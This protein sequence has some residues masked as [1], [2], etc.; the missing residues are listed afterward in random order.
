MKSFGIRMWIN[1]I[2]GGEQILSVEQNHINNLNV[3]PVP[4][5]DTG[6]NMYTTISGGLMCVD[7]EKY[8]TFE[9]YAKILTK[10]MLMN[11]RGNS[12]VI[13]SQ[14]FRGF[15]SN[16]DTIQEINVDS[17]KESFRL[18]K[19]T[20]YKSVNDPVEGTILTIIREIAENISKK[21]YNE[22]EELF[23]DV[24]LFGQKSLD[25]TPNLLVELKEVGVVDS[26]GYGLLAFLK[27]MNA[28]LNNS[29]D[30]LINEIKDKNKSEDSAYI[31][32][33]HEF[34]S[35]KKDEGFGYCSEVII[36]TEL[37]I[38]PYNN[39]NKAKPTIKSLKNRLQNLG[40][41]LVFVQHENLIKIH[42][43]TMYPYKLLE[44][45]QK[46]GEFERIKIENMTLQWKNKMES[47]SDNK[48]DDFQ[49]GIGMLMTVPTEEI[50]NIVKTDFGISEVIITE[51]NLAP[52][53]SQFLDAAFAIKRKNVIII[54]DDSNYVI[55]AKESERNQNKITIKV[56]PSKN[57]IEAMVCAAMFDNTKS[58]TRNIFEMN[59][60]LRKIDSAVIS[61]ASKNVKYKHLEVK[62]NDWIGIIDK[63]VITSNNDEFTTLKLTLDKL[64]K[65]NKFDLCFIV[66]GKNTTDQ[67]IKEFEDYA[68][69]QYGLVCEVRDGNQKTYNYYIG[70]Q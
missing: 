30:A 46:Y 55:S 12:G 37:E 40:D 69:M 20:A 31:E 64:I 53:V 26:G 59:N 34:F 8:Q 5:G 49:E 33:N 2:H 43:H 58:L 21:E 41:S 29:L 48:F 3:F 66:R 14:I 62:K 7:E 10:S 68:L 50:G 1:M 27:G 23:N 6:S 57:L 38:N 18:A 44:L 13:F 15:M 65:N 67:V 35:N 63:K 70:L 28:A 22:I 61:I 16:F 54:T 9:S 42:I 56:I 4:D 24:I 60:Q 17:L 52:N 45:G 11:A 47:S 25:N 39:N 32:E 36:N 19:E 51:N